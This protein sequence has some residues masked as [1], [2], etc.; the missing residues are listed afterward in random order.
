[1]GDLAYNCA[2]WIIGHLNAESPTAKKKGK[3]FKQYEKFNYQP[4][5]IHEALIL[6]AK[7]DEVEV[8]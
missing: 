2:R 7:W 6:N 5:W 3:C 8:N 1:M 4:I